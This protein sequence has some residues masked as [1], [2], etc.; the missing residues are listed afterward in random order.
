VTTLEDHLE[1]LLP[2]LVRDTFLSLMPS[3]GIHIEQKDMQ[4]LPEGMITG[5]VPW[6]SGA[7]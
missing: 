4:E 5:V 3:L 6:S 2:Q 7:S 1:I